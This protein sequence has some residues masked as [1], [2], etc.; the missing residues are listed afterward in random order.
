VR[1][2]GELNLGHPKAP[3]V[4]S[5][6]TE[7]LRL[8]EFGEDDWVD[9]HAIESDPEVA[10]YQSFE[11]RTQEEAQA[12]VQGTMASAREEPRATYDLAVVLHGSHTVVGRCGLHITKADAREAMVW[13]TLQR[14]LWGR[15][16]IPEALRAVVDFGFREL[17]LHRIW[18]ECDPA[19]RPS[20]RVLEKIDMRREGHL[21]ENAWLKGAWVDSYIY[22]ILG[23]EWQS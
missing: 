11:P 22:A 13:Y 7:R 18:A 1:F 2:S 10:R 5:L 23:R 8:R 16:Y 3:T 14:A 20:Y 17:G 19:N 15:G 21:R 6:T 4:V 9:L 12:Y